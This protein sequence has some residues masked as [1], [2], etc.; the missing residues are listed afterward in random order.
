MRAD[1]RNCVECL[2]TLVWIS[3]CNANDAKNILFV[4][5]IRLNQKQETRKFFLCC[6]ALNVFFERNINFSIR[7]FYKSVIFLCRSVVQMIDYSFFLF[8]WFELNVTE[9]RRLSRS[10]HCCC[11]AVQGIVRRH[12]IGFACPIHLTQPLTRTL[13]IFLTHTRNFQWLAFK[14]TN[15]EGN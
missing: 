12:V 7:G 13:S 9:R 15:S 4:L 14:M 10:W 3:S 11:C 6:V 5:L 1:K 2:Y 8:S